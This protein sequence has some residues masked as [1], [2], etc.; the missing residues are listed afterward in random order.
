MPVPENIC[1]D[2]IQAS[3]F[4][5]LYKIRPHLGHPKKKN[6]KPKNVIR[7]KRDEQREIDRPLW[8]KSKKKRKNNK[9]H[10]AHL[11]K[12]LRRAS[13]VVNGSRNEYPPLPINNNSPPVVGYRGCNPTN[14]WA[15]HHHHHQKRHRFGPQPLPH[16]KLG[17][18]GH[19]PQY[20]PAIYTKQWP[21]FLGLVFFASPHFI[22]YFC[23]ASKRKRVERESGGK[24]L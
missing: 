2:Y 22:L 20:P 21:F 11:G 16:S 19:H 10:E 15:Q 24:Q 3:F 4:G 23:R 8:W 17:T 7:D 14:Q 6:Q 5:L 12:Y 1:L 13:W 18:H 9:T